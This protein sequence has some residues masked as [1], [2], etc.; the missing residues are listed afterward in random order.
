MLFHIALGS[1]EDIPNTI[2]GITVLS[3]CLQNMAKMTAFQPMSTM[4][5]GKKPFIFGGICL[6]HRFKTQVLKLSVPLT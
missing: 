2:G 3:K 5:Q 6:H 4:V 1:L